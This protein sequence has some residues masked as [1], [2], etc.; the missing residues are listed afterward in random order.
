MHVTPILGVVPP[1]ASILAA[2]ASPTSAQ[3]NYGRNRTI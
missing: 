3:R 1:N 2:R